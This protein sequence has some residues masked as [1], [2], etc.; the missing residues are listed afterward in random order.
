[1]KPEQKAVAVSDEA[2]EVFKKLKSYNYLPLQQL[3][4][5]SQLSNKKWDKAIK[6]LT[7]NAL[8]SVDKNPQDGSYWVKVEE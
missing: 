4:E 1:M 8:A 7:S 3:K 2:K 5:E 6:E